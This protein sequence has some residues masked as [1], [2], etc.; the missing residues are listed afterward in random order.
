MTINEIK[1]KYADAFGHVP[2]AYCPIVGDC[3]EFQSKEGCDGYDEAYHRI[4]KFLEAD[5]AIDKETEEQPVDMVNRPPHYTHGMECIDE[6]IQVFG[7]ASVMNFCICNAWK[8]RKRAMYKNG[9]EDMDK[10]DWYIKK[11]VELKKGV[12]SNV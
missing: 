1:R 8:Y 3:R 6:M 9:Q 2:C 7:V 10:A 4:A 12:E 5:E 11:Y